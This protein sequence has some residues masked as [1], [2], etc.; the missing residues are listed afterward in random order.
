M[1]EG[2]R[3]PPPPL[4]VIESCPDCGARLR[5][6]RRRADREPFL[7]CSA[8]PRCDFAEDIDERSNR[9]AE[10]IVEL[11]DELALAEDQAA[12]DRVRLPASIVS[13]GLLEIIALAHPDRR[14]PHE[15]AF[16]HEVTVALNRLRDSLRATA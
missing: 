4:L 15:L 1:A 12:V 13:K 14:A 5:V 8:W 11:E 16:A 10:R 7:A 3:E 6:K 2:Y 9:L